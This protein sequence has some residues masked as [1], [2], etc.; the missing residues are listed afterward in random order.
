MAFKSNSYKLGLASMRGDVE[1]DWFPWAAEID[2]ATQELSMK[3]QGLNTDIKTLKISDSFRVQWVDYVKLFVAWRD[4]TWFNSWKRRD[5]LLN[6]RRRFND[7]HAALKSQS[8]DMVTSPYDKRSISKDSSNEWAPIA[9]TGLVVLGV[10]A[11]AYAL[12]QITGFAK[13][14]RGG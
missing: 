7:F 12:G 9:K 14:V 10:L 5:E 3:I 8:N 6:F 11:G 4:S 1:S 2:A 13:T